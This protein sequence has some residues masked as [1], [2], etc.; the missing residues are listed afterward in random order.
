MHHKGKPKKTSRQDLKQD[1]EEGTEAETIEERCSL[2]CPP[3]LDQ[4]SYTI[5]DVMRSGGI[6]HSK[7][8]P[9]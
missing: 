6:A 8:G 5:Q 9:Q 7:L 2:A 3:W 1:P 4:L